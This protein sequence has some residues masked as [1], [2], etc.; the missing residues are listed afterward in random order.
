MYIYDLKKYYLDQ[1][2][3]NKSYLFLK[4]EALIVTLDVT[5]LKFCSSP[6]WAIGP[7]IDFKQFYLQI[8]MLRRR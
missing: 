1:S 2:I 3:Q 7:L 6:M 8:Q 5:G 4:T